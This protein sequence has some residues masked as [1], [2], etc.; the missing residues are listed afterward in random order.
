MAIVCE[1][2]VYE[3]VEPVAEIVHNYRKPVNK[4]SRVADALRWLEQEQ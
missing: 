4:F 1:A 2:D 3:T